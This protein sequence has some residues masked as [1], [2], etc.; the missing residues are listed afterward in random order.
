MTSFVQDATVPPA[1]RSRIIRAWN[2][3][4]V[5]NPEWLNCPPVPAMPE[6]IGE[7]LVNIGNGQAEHMGQLN[8]PGVFCAGM[9]PGPR[10]AD[11]QMENLVV[12]VNVEDDTG[13]TFKSPTLMLNLFPDLFPYGHGD[14]KLEHYKTN[15]R[16]APEAVQGEDIPMEPEGE[17]E[18]VDAGAEELSEFE[19]FDIEPFDVDSLG[20]DP[21][22]GGDVSIDSD[23]DGDDDDDDDPGD[24]E[25][26]DS[27]VDM[28]VEDEE[29]EATRESTAIQYQGVLRRLQPEWHRVLSYILSKWAP[30]VI[31]KRTVD[32]LITQNNSGDPTKVVVSCKRRTGDPIVDGLVALHQMHRHTP[33]YCMKQSKKCHFGFPMVVSD[34]TVFD[35]DTGKVVLERGQE[36]MYVNAYNPDIL[37]ICRSNIGIQLNKGSRSIDCLHKY[38]SQVS[39]LSEGVIQEVPVDLQQPPP[40]NRQR[41]RD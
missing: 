24:D 33:Y 23:P 14:F 26:E 12:G 19:P 38:T 20:L 30:K 8:F 35:E 34:K 9:D 5:H 36:D 18:V 22:Q 21:D 16:Q 1:D 25:D 2:W 27:D 11:A 17:Q 28:D 29:N 40:Q 4:R 32:E 10:A 31:G 13:V 15:L 39:S 41:L 6:Q 37:K 3:L 7:G